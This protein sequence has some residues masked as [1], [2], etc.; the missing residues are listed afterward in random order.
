MSRRIALPA[1][2]PPIGTWPAVMR[3]DMAAAYLDYR[4]TGELA[5]AVGRGEAPPPIGYRGVGRA[6]EPVWSKAVIDNVTASGK[7][8][9]PD[10][11]Q[12]QDLVSLV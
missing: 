7:A 6:R 3:A 2:Y 12:G 5:R 8:V 11:L 1:R 10:G 9:D 4:D